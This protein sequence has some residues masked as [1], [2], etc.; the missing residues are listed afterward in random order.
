MYR[1]GRLVNATE[2]AADPLHH[3]DLNIALESGDAYGVPLP[4]TSL[5][6][7]MLRT[8]R[9]QGHGALDHSALLLVVEEL[10][11]REPALA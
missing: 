7:Q 8:L 2:W 5:V 1:G 4:A 3:K 11:A 10:A 6:Q 9:A